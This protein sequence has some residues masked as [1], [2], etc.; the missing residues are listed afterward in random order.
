[1]RRFLI[2]VLVAAS[3]VALGAQGSLSLQGF[4]Y[5]VGQGSTRATGTAGA[6]A[7]TDAASPVNPAALPA[8]GRSM[9]TF[10]IEPEFRRIDINGRPVNTKTVRFPNISAGARMGTR[11]FLAASFSTLLDRTWDASFADTVSVGGDRV[12]STVSTSVRGAISDARVGFGWVFSDALQ[13]GVA[14][15]AYT[16][17]NRMRLERLFSDTSTFGTLTQFT[18]LSYAGTAVSAGVVARPLPHWFVAGSLRLGGAMHTR[19][20][21]SL[22]T[23]GHVPNRYGLSLTYDGIPGSQLA[24]RVNHEAW[25][26]MQPMGT[27]ALS[28]KDVTEISAGAEISGPKLGSNLTTLRLGARSRDLP[29]ALNGSTISEQTFAAG[30]GATVARGWASIDISMQHASRK[31][32][33]LSETGTILSVG[34]TVRP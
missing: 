11:G 10:Q 13:A 29:F 8:A 21:D 15:H 27:S 26:R 22:A 33:G 4:G 24:V 30:F 9:F 28:A 17:A 31:G 25:S 12:P 7:E 18:N 19:I 2:T 3:P 1:M 20:D 5:P 32:G 23:K 6:L 16:G 14:F 34:L